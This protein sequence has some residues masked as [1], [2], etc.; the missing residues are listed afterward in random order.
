M[1]EPD[2]LDDDPFGDE[3]GNV[4]GAETVF[5]PLEP[6]NRFFFEF[7]DNLYY[8]ILKPVNRFY[9]IVVPREFRTC[10]GNFFYNLA[11]PI[12]LVNNLLQGD[13]VDAGAVLSRFV[14]NSTL[15][16]YGFGDVASQEFGLKPRPGDLGQTLGVWGV[17]EGAYLCLPVFGP[18]NLRDIVGFAGDSYMHP[19]GHFNDGNM[20]A[21]IAFYTGRQVNNLSLN[22]NV[23]EELKSYALDP[24]VSM[25]EAYFDYRVKLISGD[26]AA[27]GH[28]QP[29]MDQEGKYE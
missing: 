10:F 24:Y 28:P 5:D 12:R 26:Q 2:W 16:V 18:S 7:N 8:L 15:G 21:N 14:I 4:G 9:S 19:V 25:R 17:G 11:S 20:V 3:G 6:M 23:Y 1:E 29:L 27:D 22:P 13:F